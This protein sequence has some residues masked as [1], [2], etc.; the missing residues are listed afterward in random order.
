VPQGGDYDGV[1]GVV[2]PLEIL[3]AAR[4][5]GTADHLPLELILFAEEEGT[6]FGL[7][8]L[9]SRAWVGE[10][11]AKQLAEI[12]NQA[13]QNYLEAGRACGVDPANF[14]RD[15]LA[16]AARHRGFIEVH[17]EQGPAMWKRNE[18]IAIVRAIA[19]RRQY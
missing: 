13:G 9:G 3:R 11:A 5:D 15:R 16:P 18:R 8:M 2:V 10:L 19:G 4:E 12:H 1:A 7:G 6:T 17:I 14:A